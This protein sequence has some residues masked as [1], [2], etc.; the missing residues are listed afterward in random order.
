[1]VLFRPAAPLFRTILSRGGKYL[2]P[3]QDGRVLAGSTEEDVGF[4]ARTTVCGIAGL[5]DFVRSL[6]PTDSLALF[7]HDFGAPMAL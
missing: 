2:V 3:R 4:D 5:L 6:V 1:M 7:P